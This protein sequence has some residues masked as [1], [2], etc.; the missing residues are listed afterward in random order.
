VLRYLAERQKT[1]PIAKP[2]HR[3]AVY[4]SILAAA[5]MLRSSESANSILLI[6]D[7]LDNSSKAH[8][9]ET[10]RELVVN[11]IV[12]HAILLTPESLRQHSAFSVEEAQANDAIR[13]L[14]GDSGGLV[15][16]PLGR[17][18]PGTNSSLVEGIS[19]DLADSEKKELA[20]GL[21]KF[22]SSILHDELVELQI[23]APNKKWRKLTISLSKE[24]S[25][26]AK[27]LSLAY[28]RQFP[29]CQN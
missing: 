14:I 2:R 10:A 16:G 22:Y 23:A 12:L 21:T 17:V 8:I 5:A 27:S 26:A 28:P 4:D 3:T 20:Q 6:S 18:L 15:Y 1:P 11:G 24:K 19:Y 25:E 9:T 13:E 7:G 29:A